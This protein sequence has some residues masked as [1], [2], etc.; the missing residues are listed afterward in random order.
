MS[1]SHEDLTHHAPAGPLLL[2][3][4]RLL[5]AHRDAFHQERVYARASWLFIGWLFAFSRKT[6]TQL[7][8]S[9]GWVGRDWSA[10]YRLLSQPRLAYE[11]LAERLFEQTLCHVPAEQ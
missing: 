9:L 10:W 3:L 11:R 2:E 4:W 1:V 6:M 8:V 7:L 5:Q